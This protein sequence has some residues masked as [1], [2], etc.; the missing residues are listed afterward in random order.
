MFTRD[1]PSHPS[2]KQTWRRLP[3]RGH[4]R[5]LTQQVVIAAGFLSVGIRRSSCH[6]PRCEVTAW[7]HTEHATPRDH[8]R[9]LEGWTSGG[10]GVRARGATRP[11][12][13]HL[14][15]GFVGSDG[16]P[17]YIERSSRRRGRAMCATLS[18]CG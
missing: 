17:S 9:N 13:S 2:S 18:A 1:R 14:L 4:L 7:W 8:F 15:L 3:A 16:A 10:A 12:T 5:H 6:S 11:G